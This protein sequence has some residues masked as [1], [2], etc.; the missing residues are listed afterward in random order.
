ML[1]LLRLTLYPLHA[2]I[3]HLLK[4][5]DYSKEYNSYKSLAYMFII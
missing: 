5:T 2:T 1:G 4:V 3:F